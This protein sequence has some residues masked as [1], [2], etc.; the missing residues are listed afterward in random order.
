LDVYELVNVH[1]IGV[2][3]EFHEVC[4]GTTRPKPKGWMDP[5]GYSL[6]SSS[7]TQSQG[8]NRIRQW[9]DPNNVYVSKTTGLLGGNDQNYYDQAFNEADILG[10]S[11]LS[12]T[13]LINA[14]GNL[15]NSKV[16]LGVAFGERNQTARML[17]DTATR[18]AKSLKQLKRGQFKNA[19]QTLGLRAAPRRP[20]GDNI[21]K[22]WLALQYG[23]KPLLSDVYGAAHEL[24]N[25]KN[26][27][28]RVTAT[29]RARTRKELFAK[30][31]Y[32]GNSLPWTVSGSHEASVICRIDAI[33]KNEVLTSFSRLGVTNPLLVA[34]EL[35]P[36]SFVFDWMIPIGDYLDSLDAML[37]YGSDA[38]TC[39]SAIG[40]LR[41][42]VS[43]GSRAGQEYFTH[44]EIQSGYNGSKKVTRLVRSV[45]QG[46]Q[47]PALPSFKNPASAS[48]MANGLSLLA[49]VCSK[50]WRYF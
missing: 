34:W 36:F 23:W 33:P 45:S 24:S 41:M 17:G 29:G 15:K 19:A 26:S 32:G 31:P 16:N 39:T 44:Y 3:H 40:R 9:S 37:G 1:G 12:N 49:Q 43:G 14:L 42:N 46:Y 27:D 5:T 7:I 35:V 30:E 28:F 22:E 18:I 38:W 2:G 4:E 50:G 13:A 8:T 48:H 20:R 25:R 21:T 6:Y 10:P 47:L 11:S